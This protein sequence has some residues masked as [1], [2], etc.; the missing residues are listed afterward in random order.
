M[1]TAVDILC[2]KLGVNPLQWRLQNMF[3]KGMLDQDTGT[4]ISHH[5]LRDCLEWAANAID[6]NQKWHAPGTSTLTDGRKH[7]VGLSMLLRG[8]GGTSAVVGSIVNMTHDGKATINS[9][10][11]RASGGT[12]TGMCHIVA[13]TLGLSS[14]DDVNMIQGETD[15]SSDGGNQTGSTR[16]P[17]MGPAFMVAA[18]DCR[19]QLLEAAAIMLEVTP[20]ELDAS[21]GKIFV[22][23]DPSQFETIAAVCASVSWTIIGRGYGWSRQLRKEVDGQPVGSSCNMGGQ[24]VGACE[25]AVDTETGEVEVL[26]YGYAIDVGRAVF[27]KG[28]MGQAESS[29]DMVIGQTLHWGDILDPTTGALLNN[30]FVESRYPTAPD[31]PVENNKVKLFESINACGPFGATGMG[32]PPAEVNGCLNNAIANAIGGRIGEQPINPQ[33]ILK[34]LGKA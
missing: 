21:D 9:G 20:D 16:V 32:E 5:G 31:M 27:W 28:A 4:A 19:K 33:K 15:W 26:K 13:E 6:W 12:S 17:T 11:T 30:A 14:I 25:V 7:G 23:A 22:K 2:E 24:P 10:I 34:A 3:P 1:E 18:L 29:M 8:L